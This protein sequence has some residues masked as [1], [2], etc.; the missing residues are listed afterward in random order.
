MSIAEKNERT[1]KYIRI[2]FLLYHIHLFMEYHLYHYT[3][4]IISI[5]I[6]IYHIFQQKEY[7]LF[8]NHKSYIQRDDQI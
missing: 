7:Y 2:F 4:M 1:I 8:D 6:N 3:Y 5:R